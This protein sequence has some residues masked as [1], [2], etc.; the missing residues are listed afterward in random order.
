M[1]SYKRKAAAKRAQ[2]SRERRKMLAYKAK[3]LDKYSSKFQDS[4][5]QDS[6]F[7]KE[8]K[9]WLFVMDNSDQEKMIPTLHDCW[10]LGRK[11]ITEEEYEEKYGIGKKL[12]LVPLLVSI[13]KRHKEQWYILINIFGEMNKQHEGFV[14][15][16]WS[17]YHLLSEVLMPCSILTKC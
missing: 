16:W 10:A 6:E 17:L 8:K 13:E 2:S 15:N 4:E 9:D 7:P 3:R 1:N 11:E 5:F 14:D 12:E